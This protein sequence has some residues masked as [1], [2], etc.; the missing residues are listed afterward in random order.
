MINRNGFTL[1]EM[2]A[3]IAILMLLALVSTPF[4]K[5]YIDDSYYGK[6]KIFL[7]QLNE[8]RMNFEKDYPGLII[9]GTL[10]ELG[11]G[12]S[13]CQIE[14]L[15]GASQEVSPSELV[16]CHYVKYPTDLNGRYTF[17]VK[18]NSFTS[19]CT[20]APGSAVV[21]MEGADTSSKYYQECTTI[22]NVGRVYHG[23]TQEE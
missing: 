6:A 12:A 11:E 10:E 15:Y 19:H 3:V 2:V 17:S 20:S 21:A 1:A 16:R 14:N 8:A 18:K 5:S 9:A 13:T 7:R 23:D 4:V 22:D